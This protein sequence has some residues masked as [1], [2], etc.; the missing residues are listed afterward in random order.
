[1]QDNMANFTG[2]ARHTVPRMMPKFKMFRQRVTLGKHSGVDG[3]VG[4]GH[5]HV[6]IGTGVA[7]QLVGKRLLLLTR[8]QGTL[9]RSSR[10][11]PKL[12]GISQKTPLWTK[13]QSFSVRCEQVKP[14]APR[15]E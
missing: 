5:T 1:M 11:P 2:E 14:N 13:V 8:L 7:G 15:T 6:C 12:A 10:A 9:H 3:R 4:M